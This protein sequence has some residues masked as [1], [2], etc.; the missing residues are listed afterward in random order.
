MKKYDEIFFNEDSSFYDKFFNLKMKD[1]LIQ[2]VDYNFGN[3]IHV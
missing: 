2:S 3:Y 1:G